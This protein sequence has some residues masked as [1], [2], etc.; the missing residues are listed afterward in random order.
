M[1]MVA[2]LVTGF[3]PSQAEA[4]G[5][6]VPVQAVENQPADGQELDDQQPASPTAGSARGSEA[7]TVVRVASI[8]WDWPGRVDHGEELTWP[9][10]IADG[11]SWWLGL[12]ISGP[13]VPLRPS[14][15]LAV[16]VDPVALAQVPNEPGEPKA[17]AAW[18]L[19]YGAEA[20]GQDR[21]A[22]HRAALGLEDSGRSVLME[23]YVDLNAMRR[24]DPERSGWGEVAKLLKTWRLSNARDIMI[25][26]S[27]SPRPY[28]LPMVVWLDVTWASRSDALDVVRGKTLTRP[29][30]MVEAAE[31]SPAGVS[32][33]LALD[34]D[35]RTAIA[36][37]L[38]SAIASRHEDPEFEQEALRWATRSRDRITRMQAVLDEQALVVGG[39]TGVGVRIP[40]RRQSAGRSVVSDITALQSRLGAVAQSDEQAQAGGVILSPRTQLRW[41]VGEALRSGGLSWLSI[42]LHGAHASEAPQP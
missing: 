1:A 12:P 9:S 32:W 14:G 40:L 5:P 27:A 23:C 25:H 16:M 38:G 41:W 34:A 3:S 42:D 8:T 7:G 31:I 22:L 39:D 21:A 6:L 29:L 28:P 10:T 26:A 4:Q 13:Q 15:S 33:V 30:G 20:G 17:H 19:V 36:R 11:L 37:A 18:S 24:S 35:V 2:M